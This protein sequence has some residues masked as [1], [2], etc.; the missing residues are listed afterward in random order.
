MRS[1]CGD[2][3][4]GEKRGPGRRED[5][6]GARHLLQRSGQKSETRRHSTPLRLL[7]AHTAGSRI[8]GSRWQMRDEMRRR[9]DRLRLALCLSGEHLQIAALLGVAKPRN[10]ELPSNHRSLVTR[11]AAP[12]KTSS[13]SPP[14]KGHQFRPVGW[15]DEGEICRMYGD[16]SRDPS[17]ISP[18]PRWLQ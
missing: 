1:A 14:S 8:R 11:P 6:F 17:L 3:G 16:L 12:L 15:H 7:Q 9:P 10:R 4:T 5:I 2:S 18:K 13:L